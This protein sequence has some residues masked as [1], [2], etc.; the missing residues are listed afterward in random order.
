VVFFGDSLKENYVFVHT[1]C[2]LNSYT[3]MSL[4]PYVC[5]ILE[6]TVS[7]LFNFMLPFTSKQLSKLSKVCL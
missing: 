3:G 5:G 6:F 7:D 2:S 1:R 4:M